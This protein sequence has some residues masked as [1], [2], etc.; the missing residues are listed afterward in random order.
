M[1]AKTEKKRRNGIKR[2]KAKSD[3]QKEKS[4]EDEESE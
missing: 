4:F 1:T 2:E 3:Q